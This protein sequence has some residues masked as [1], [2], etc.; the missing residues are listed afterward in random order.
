VPL[1]PSPL[2]DGGSPHPTERGR[3][4]RWVKSGNTFSEQMS[5]AVHPIVLQKSFCGV[6]LK[7]SGPQVRRL[8]KDVRDHVAKRQT[9]R[10]FC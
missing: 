8:N 5:S 9:H 3:C 6:G 4:P 1:P 7:F 2:S 10:R